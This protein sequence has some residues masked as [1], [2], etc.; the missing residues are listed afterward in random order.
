MNLQFFSKFRTFFPESSGKSSAPD[1][2]FV[3]GLVLSISSLLFIAG[4]GVHA[5]IFISASNGSLF[6]LNSSIE[7]GSKGLNRVEIIST[8]QKLD[9][10]E[11]EG[12]Q[13]R[14]SPASIGSL[15]TAP[16]GR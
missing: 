11:K 16:S 10:K 14:A 4:I 6:G 12:I 2:H 13:L 15:G 9:L 3:W 1:P 7:I 8:L 5:Y